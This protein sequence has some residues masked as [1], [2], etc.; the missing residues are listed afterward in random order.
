[1]KILL[2]FGRFLLKLRLSRIYLLPMSLLFAST[3][4]ASDDGDA[5]GRRAVLYAAKGTFGIQGVLYT[6][7]PA[8]GAVLTVVGL[9]NDTAGNNYGM[10]G[11]RYHPISGI[12]YGA[13]TTTSPTTAGSGEAR[14]AAVVVRPVSDGRGGWLV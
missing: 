2:R 12:F 4:D 14:S 13:T 11:L 8:T 6:L 10:G 3:L 9:L 1:M 7:D 5:A